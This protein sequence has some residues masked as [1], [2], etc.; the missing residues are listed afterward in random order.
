MAVPI[1]FSPANGFPA[2]VYQALFAA[3]APHPVS[4]LPVTGASLRD[5]PRHWQPLVDE[6]VEALT[7][8]HASPVVGL[9]HS[10]GAVLMLRAAQQQPELFFRVIMLD[11]PLFGP[12]KRLIIG[13]LRSLGLAHRMIPIVKG[14]LRRRDHFTSREEALA[15]WQP[16]KLFRHF[17]PQS[18]A[19]YV[20]HGLVPAPDGG[21][22]LRIPKTR[23][24][25]IF[26]GTPSRV[27]PPL[28][29]L[30]SHLLYPATGG[31]STPR[32]IRTLQRALPTT[33][34]ESFPG[35]HMFPLEQPEALGQRLREFVE[36]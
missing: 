29:G 21:F 35:G 22:R 9:G 3:L 32:E 20:A 12:G 4:F 15:Y 7:A 34:F 5:E 27:G 11:P 25:N 33:A 19:A 23:E 28:T 16:K 1:H 6:L 30:S 10:L 13:L 8:T 2:E 24:A 17:P 31:V 26:A 36:G 14:A 18:L